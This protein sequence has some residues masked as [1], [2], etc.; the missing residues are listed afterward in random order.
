[1]KKA[2][3]WVVAVLLTA[4]TTRSEKKDPGNYLPETPKLT[5]DIMTPEVLWSFGRLAEPS[6]S[7]DGK[8]VAYTVTYYN[9]P[10]NKSL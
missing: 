4:C 10:E 6:V 7:H 2:T 9:V 1:M 5:S 3:I 8:Y